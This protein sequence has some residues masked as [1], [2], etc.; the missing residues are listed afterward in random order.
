MKNDFSLFVAITNYGYGNAAHLKNVI[1]AFQ[2]MPF[3]VTV[4]ILSDRPKVFDDGI[5][6]RVGIP[7]RS[8]WTLPFAYK[9][10]FREN[11]GKFDLYV[12]VEDDILVTEENVRAFMECSDLLPA[13]AIAGF[14]RFERD[15]SGRKYFI[16]IFRAFHFLPETFCN[17]GGK[18]FV[19]LNNE[20]AGCFM[21]T[22]RQLDRAL[23]HPAFLRKP[24]RGLYGFAET[25]ATEPYTQCGVKKL[26]CVSEL[27][28]FSLHHLPN[29]YCKFDA[30]RLAAEEVITAQVESMR[31]RDRT[32]GTLFPTQVK[33]DSFLWD[34]YYYPL[35]DQEVLRLL[36]DEAAPGRAL[37]IGCGSGATEL[38][39]MKAGWQVSA[40][41]LDGVIAT[42]AGRQGVE[43]LPAS[44]RRGMELASR[45]SFDA[46]LLLNVLQFVRDPV[47]LLERCRGLLCPSGVLVVR[48]PNFF[49]VSTLRR[50]LDGSIGIADA[51][52]LLKYVRSGL[53][54]TSKHRLENWIATAGLSSVKTEE[55]S[56]RDRVTLALRRWL[57]GFTPR[58]LGTKEYL[59]VAAPAARPSRRAT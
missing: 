24:H 32:H 31:A 57:S 14:T 21:L 19:E 11:A 43:I 58:V 35:P 6:V 39:L 34:K 38:E 41:P 16:D 7:G 51:F 27:E 8:P 33:I 48:V 46:I 36:G 52:R 40:M 12:Y 56:G 15:E 26:L 30:H 28:R 29:K 5:K 53:R 37:S 2:A 25:A 59:I 47:S 17:H 42:H 54:A 50:V 23:R 9:D 22:R 44:W 13:D 55:I 49:H 20:H 10:A 1:A 4:E 3:K 45:Q 18:Q